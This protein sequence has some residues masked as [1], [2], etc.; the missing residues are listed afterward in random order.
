MIKM[1]LVA[2]FRR[3]AKEKV[4]VL[5]NVLGLALGIASF[6]I[7]TLY[8]RSE[9][10]YDQHHINY[11]RIYRVSSHFVGAGDSRADYARTAGG[12]G[13]LLVQDH[14][15]FNSF[16]RFLPSSQNALSFEE[17]QF[18]WDD[19]FYAD[20]NIF[21]VF[22]H[23]ILHGDPQTAFIDSKSIAISESLAHSYFGD[24]DPIGK[25]LVGD[26][27]SYRVTLVFADFPENTHLKYSALF[28]YSALSDFVPNYEDNYARSLTLLN[29]FTY[30]FTGP[31][32]D[33]E[34]FNEISEEFVEKYMAQRLSQINSSFR[35]EIT[36]LAS[37]H[38]GEPLSGDEPN[39]NK[40]YLYG[41]SIVATFILL[42]ACIN[43]MILATAQATKRA[44]EI[45]MRKVV[46]ASRG[47]LI[48]QIF[49]E[50]AIFTIIA[51]LLGIIMA[52]FVL[53]FTP[54]SS[55]LGNE[56]LLNGSIDKITIFGFVIMAFSVTVISGLYPAFY[57][58]SIPPMAALTTVNNSRYVGLSLRQILILVQMAISIGVIV[59]TLFMSAQMQYI[60]N[61]PLG[62]DKE[63]KVL[64]Q[65]RGAN[66]LED[67]SALRSELIAN[68]NIS[69]VIETEFI[70]G[71]GSASNSI[72]IQNNEGVVNP[73]IVDRII[74]GINYIDGL[75]VQ[76]VEGR[77]FDELII[78]DTSRVVMVNEAMV[79]KMG[80][81]E[82]IGKSIYI[83]RDASTVIGVTADFHYASL[84]NEIGPLVIQPISTNF[85]N[86]STARRPLMTR[87][88]IVNISG[89]EVGETLNT[90]ERIIRQFDP[91]HVFDPSFLDARLDELYS[92]ETA[93]LK[94]LEIF[95]AIC[96][97]ISA[98][99]MFG[100]ASFNSMQRKN[101][102][103][104]R[105]VLGAS[106]LQIL[107]M[108]SKNLL[109]FVIVASIPAF[110]V[111]NAVIENWLEIFAYRMERD[112]LASFNIYLTA[113]VVVGIVTLSI[114]IAQS[115]STVQSNLIDV[116]RHE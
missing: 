105:K 104:V 111:S 95:A 101:E 30:L 56:S 65:L 76:V 93:L 28:P 86:I 46:G 51:L 71:F 68:I 25:I 52:V 63:N 55:L 110:I 74:V 116:L 32:F 94:L 9:L 73:E 57:L 98:M 45:G 27:F 11:E 20:E 3:I 31:D 19:I 114:V 91:A 49:G 10:S 12:I 80:W 89:Q 81:D 83:S 43:Y 13:P 97:F 99:G 35:A 39:G 4:Y 33:P 37:I 15:Q 67:I 106:T 53:G 62:F 69:S 8:L 87:S 26:G 24:D 44:K 16:V 113:T 88:I 72:P 34:T 96:I 48:G 17:I 22:T 18:V 2:I 5:L 64:I 82:P 23:H 58:S 47:E 109:V 85:D 115:I 79:R 41:F 92:R 29:G 1:H 14:S 102:I 84:N 78:N 7:I 50:S 21:E 77:N 59:C 54:L 70:P 36:P 107:L 103:G 66:V 60:A 75:G 108:L 61:K 38:Y 112:F 90:I 6:I 100:L 40:F 42:V